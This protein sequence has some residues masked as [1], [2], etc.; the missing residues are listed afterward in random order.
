MKLQ[1][2]YKSIIYNYYI[3]YCLKWSIFIINIK[4][5]IIIYNK[6]KYYNVNL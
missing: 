6:L 5:M 4:F 1:I 2:I 3:D